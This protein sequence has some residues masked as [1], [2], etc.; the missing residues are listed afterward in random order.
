MSSQIEPEIKLNKG[1][2]RWEMAKGRSP[3]HPQLPT[4][5]SLP[6]L[7]A[8]AVAYSPTQPGDKAGCRRDCG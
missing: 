5:H 2:N 6:N 7:T 4:P 3:I 8:D 1:V